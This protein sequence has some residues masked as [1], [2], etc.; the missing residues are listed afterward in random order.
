MKKNLKPED[1]VVHD[2]QGKVIPPSEGP[3]S[4]YGKP[5][6]AFEGL[7]EKPGFVPLNGVHESPPACDTMMYNYQVHHDRGVLNYAISDLADGLD[8]ITVGDTPYVAGWNGNMGYVFGT[9][10]FQYWRPAW[11]ILQQSDAPPEAKALIK[12]AM[13]L[14]GDRL[15]MSA[16]IERTNGNA[17]S[18][19]PM[20]LRYAAEGTKDPL[21][22]QLSETY[23]DRFVSEGWG[24]GTGISKSG[25]L[26]GALCP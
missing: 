11:R 6:V 14:C 13:I 5:S 25:R 9:Y 26:P 20:A 12:E 10:F 3:K 4:K 22:T 21:L 18:H 19:I 1:F 17:L 24:R 8:W 2:A 7:P 15:A 16:G 23:F